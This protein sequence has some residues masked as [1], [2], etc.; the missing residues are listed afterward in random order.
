MKRFVVFM[1]FALLLGGMV[2][3]QPVI[4]TVDT[5]DS[6][7]DF[8]F[9]RGYRI[10][11][12]DDGLGGLPEIQAIYYRGFNAVPTI[13]TEAR[14]SA[15][16][17]GSDIDSY[18]SVTD[19]DAEIGTFFFLGA[20]P[21]AAS[22]VGSTITGGVDQTFTIT[23]PFEDHGVTLSAGFARS[24]DNFYLGLYY[25]G[26][27]LEAKGADNG[28]PKED[29]INTYES[30]WSNNLAVLVGLEDLGAFRLDLIINTE[31]DR[32]RINSDNIALE[33]NVAPTVALS[34]GGLPLFG[35]NP[36]VTI[37]FKFKDK[38]EEG[39]YD[40]DDKYISWA[41]TW[42]GSFG[43]Q[44][45]ASYDLSESSSVSAAVGFR[46]RSGVNFSGHSD[47]RGDG[48]AAAAVYEPE[49]LIAP[50]EVI[51]AIFG[52]GDDSFDV[53]LGGQWGIGLEV[54]YS[55]T[56]DTG[57]VAFGFS[58]T[59]GIA[60][61]RQNNDIAGKKT[62]ELASDNTFQFNAGIDLG[63]RVAATE[64]LAFY[65]GLGLQLLNYERT[66]H[67]GGKEYDNDATFGNADTTDDSS[68][69]ELAGFAW[70]ETKLATGGILG[71]GMTYTPV[72]NLIIG[73]GLNTFINRLFMIDVRGM[74][75]RTG[76][77]WDS[78]GGGA[79]NLGTWAG[80]LFE[81]L[82]IDLTVSYRM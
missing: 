61:M 69:W 67:S 20:F 34:W 13:S 35:F 32:T 82:Q 10:I 48:I 33:R 79:N 81:D 63:L 47:F 30:Q 36:F 58:P 6:P 26:S 25:G 22:L 24:F 16:I 68:E 64:K 54:S 1:L 59:I 18:I 43:L 14:Y 71:I 3:G 78:T 28:L 55:Q 50:A 77:F 74:R 21:S 70:D 38:I 41:E 57:M 80:R 2:W 11:I 56:I 12:E 51:D 73:F 5:D 4:S 27:F 37:G 29:N 44:F 53:T 75:I 42:D 9:G 62:L 72:E 17:F 65:T 15:G 45:G 8:A 46:T 66:T 23:D 52:T 39:G 49:L 19:Y 60:Y 7:L 40:A 76:T 31:T